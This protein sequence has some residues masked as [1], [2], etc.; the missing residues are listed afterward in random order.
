MSY[1]FERPTPDPCSEL[2]DAVRKL[3]VALNRADEIVFAARE[4]LAAIDFD[5]NGRMIGM[6]RLGGNG[7]MISIATSKTADKLRLLLSAGGR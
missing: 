4:L 2:R 3:E 5:N 7:G 6:E 1:E